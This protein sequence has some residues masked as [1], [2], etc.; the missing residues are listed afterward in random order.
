MNTSHD[1]GGAHRPDPRRRQVVVI[2]YGLVR[3]LAMLNDTLQ[4]YQNNK[5]A[6]L[7][8]LIVEAD[9]RDNCTITSSML[10][11]AGARHVRLHHSAPQSA[12]IASFNTRA[13]K[14][15]T[16][17]TNAL[18]YFVA[19]QLL[20]AGIAHAA[21]A[22][23]DAVVAW[24][25]DTRLVA[26]IDVLRLAPWEHPRRIFVSSE[27]GGI[28]LND[29]FVIAD[30]ATAQAVTEHRLRYLENLAR[31]NNSK[32]TCMYG[33]RL[34]LRSVLKLNLSVGFTRTRVVRVR[35]DLTVPDVDRALVLH[36]SNLAAGCDS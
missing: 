35:A 3:S 11:A 22:H 24:R 7:G 1:G 13:C 25:V 29:R 23:A 6:K 8:S 32:A 4:S 21:R 34:L 19:M 16:Q 15:R 2:A 17:Q 18:N 36:K 33:E 14:T 12:T 26:P 27:Q 28:G 10:R 20:N 5:P 30:L 9:C 31:Q